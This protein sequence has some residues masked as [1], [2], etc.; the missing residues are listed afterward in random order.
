M[1]PKRCRKVNLHV[2]SVVAVIMKIANKRKLS[3]FSKLISTVVQYYLTNLSSR[4]QVSNGERER[5]A[6][7]SELTVS[8]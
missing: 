1:V 8:T 3:G 4:D 5:S 2:V 6:G 7:F